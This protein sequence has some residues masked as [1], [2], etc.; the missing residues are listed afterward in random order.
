MHRFSSGATL[1]EW[2]YVNV[3]HHKVEQEINDP[4]SET[5]PR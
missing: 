3:Q 5:L 4:E 1:I 2:D